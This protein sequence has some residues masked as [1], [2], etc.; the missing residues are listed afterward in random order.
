PGLREDEFIGCKVKALA[1]SRED[2]FTVSNKRNWDSREKPF[3]TAAIIGLDS[4][5]LILAHIM[6]EC[7]IQVLPPINN[8]IY[9]YDK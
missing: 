1:M 2:D 3:S 7:Q 9:A 5:L 4:L 8:F 6:F